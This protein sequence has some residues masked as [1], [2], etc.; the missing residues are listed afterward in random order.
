MIKFVTVWVLT[1]MEVPNSGVAHTY[2]L[3]YATQKI[4][5]QQKE[6]H[7]DKRKDARCDFQQIPVYFP[8]NK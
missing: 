2:Q 3:T 8:N 7:I 4:C 6:K 1:V 5:E